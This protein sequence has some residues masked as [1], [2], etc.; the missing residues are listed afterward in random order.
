VHALIDP[1]REPSDVVHSKKITSKSLSLLLVPLTLGWFT[2]TGTAEGVSVDPSNRYYR[3]ASGNPVFLIGYYNWAAVPDGYFI[4]HPSRYATMIQRGA[5][6]QLNYVRISLG[7][8]RFT[9]TTTPQSWNNI[10]TPTPFAYVNGKANLAQ[11]DTV[12][13]TGL[14]NQCALAQQNGV[15]I[16]IAVFDGVEL[17]S[18]GGAA[19][20]YNNSF[21]NPANQTSA[22]YPAGD[23]SDTPG[24][25]YRL[26]D[27]NNNTGIGFYQKQLI[28]KTISETAAYSNVFYEIGN[29]LLGSD[30]NWNTAV[31]NYIKTLTSRPVTQVGGSAVAAINGYSDH[32]GDTSAQVKSYVASFVGHGYPAWIDPDGPGLSD[33]NVSSDELRRASWY[34]FAGGAAGWGGFTVDYWA[35]GHGF[36]STTVCYY[37][38][39]QSFINDSGIQF[40]NMIPNQSLVGNSGEN[41]C[42]ARIGE[43]VVYVLND[44]SVTV[45]LTAV[46]GTIPY[47]LYD[48]R[49]GAWST[50]QTANGGGVRTFNKP[51]GADDWVIYIGNGNGGFAGSACPPQE[52]WGIPGTQQTLGAGIT[53]GVATDSQGNIHVV[54]MNNGGIYHRR[55]NVAG[56]FAAPELIPGPEGAANYNSPHVV[57]DTNGDPHVVFERDWYPSTSKCWY[58]N[59]KGGTWKPPTLAF[60][61]LLVLYCR[62]ALYGANAFV[63]ASTAEPAGMMA[64]F[65]NLSG[66][67]HLDVTNSTYLFS[68]Y[69]VIDSTG[70]L[71]VI[72]RNSASGHYLQQY[73]QNLNPVGSG[74]KMSTGTPN[75]TGEPT[76]AAIDAANLIHAIGNCGATGIDPE[77][78]SYLWYNKSL[79]GAAPTQGSALGLIGPGWMG[80]VEF[81]HCVIDKNGILYLVY[82]NEATGEG[83]VCIV[84]NS[85]FA[86]PVTFTSAIT[87][88]NTTEQRRWNCQSAA[89]ATGGVYVTWDYNGQCYIRSI[90]A[91]V[92]PAFALNIKPAT[93]AL[94]IDGNPADWNVGEFTTTV[95][96][97]QGGS[98]DIALVGYD[99]R[100]LYYSGYYTGAT[101]P[102]NAADHTARVYSRHDANYLYFLVRN[103]DN[104]VRFPNP[105][106]MNWANDC[107]EF[108]IDPSAARG[109]IP[110]NNSTSNV[111]LV[112]DANN[113]KN[114]YVCTPAYSN[115]VLS[116]VTSAVTRDA[117]GWWLEARIA[118]A[119]LDP[120]LLSATATFGIDFNF[121]DNDNNNDTSQTT[122]YAWSDNVS[123]AGFPSK[124]PD[125]WGTAVAIPLD[126]SIDL[127]SPDI[128]NGL[129]HPQN[130]DGNTVAASIGGR[131]CRQNVNPSVDL[132]FYFGVTDTFAYQGN[133]QDLYVSVDYFNTGSGS[134]GL[135]YDSNTGNT[136]DA[137]YKDGGSVTLTGSN[138]WKRKV[139]HVTDGFFG[140]RQNAGADFRIA[141]FGG[142]AFYLDLVR[143]SSPQ[144]PPLLRA[145]RVG[146]AVTI[147][148]PA[149]TVGFVLQSANS[150]SSANWSDV[151]NNVTVVGL[152]NTL[153]DPWSNTN[154]FFRM[155][156]F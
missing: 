54:Y 133:K 129:T 34:C 154:K 21:W 57:C 25:F 59:R 135:Q 5:P 42:L 94:T 40:W 144:G 131:S 45:D 106:T 24:G 116:G 79:G 44:A 61:G 16:H 38:N 1:R 37:R 4:D 12:F 145:T 130:A 134:L 69:P 56:V 113:Q 2:L 10:P 51:A 75:K 74:I 29:E 64:R 70:K 119:A 65:S 151:T 80:H 132:Y 35:F 41:S 99:A 136:L 71:F 36:N 78:S 55:A 82:R 147:S 52:P 109:S 68:P 153:T 43:V 14:K 87:D 63:T 138:T 98:G 123:G 128:P 150:L 22:F 9:S 115:Q 6:Y 91:N 90:G 39:L 77:S 19:Y 146:N 60:H 32:V 156:K 86:E 120:D 92:A 111:Q 140:N 122:V 105:L 118:K 30:V 107:V 108:Y 15:V 13:W 26:A 112:I 126:V 11:W 48:P 117:S 28:A 17:R 33:A 148:W 58:T 27:F 110:I 142:G 49:A 93:G 95:R 53:P 139:F 83:E 102:V 141:K 62:L 18:Q 73:D 81:P 85:Q 96:G 76:A 46:A 103:D 84:T 23:Y 66:T 7:V 72:G 137:F 67:P 89:A 121:H 104:D 20:G 97:G 152:D 47:R 3:D 143:V 125:K 114:V 127:G 155:R 31:L 149:N 88:P 8:N 50:A 100:V 124:I 101:L